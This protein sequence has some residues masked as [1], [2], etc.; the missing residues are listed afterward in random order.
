[1]RLSAL[2]PEEQCTVQGPLDGASKR[3]KGVSPRQR[4]PHLAHAC[5]ASLTLFWRGIRLDS[6]WPWHGD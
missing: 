4:E 5:G 6:R 3:R 2:G 1:M